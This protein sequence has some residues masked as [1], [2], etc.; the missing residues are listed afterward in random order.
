MIFVRKNLLH[1]TMLNNTTVTNT[2]SCFGQCS[3]YSVSH[4]NPMSAVATHTYTYDIS[5]KKKEWNV[6]RNFENRLRLNMSNIICHFF[7][8]IA[9]IAAVDGDDGNEE[10]AKKSAKIRSEKKQLGL[11][12]HFFL[13]RCKRVKTNHMAIKRVWIHER[14]LDG[15]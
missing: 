12:C 14:Q 4:I 7:L 8:A 1:R 2:I 3:I 13:F 10:G 5:Q 15:K 6:F 11:R 9:P